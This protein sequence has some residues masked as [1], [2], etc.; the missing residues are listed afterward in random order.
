MGMKIYT[1]ELGH[2]VKMAAMFIYGKKS[3]KSFSPKTNGPIA[4]E[5][6]M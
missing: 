5:F 2:V 6:G 4:L 3:L 1:D